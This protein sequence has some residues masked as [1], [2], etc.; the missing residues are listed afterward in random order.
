M[1][2][3]ETYVIQ[4]QQSGRPDFECNVYV[5]DIQVKI[6]GNRKFGF[7]PGIHKHQFKHHYYD[8]YVRLMHMFGYN[9]QFC[10][11]CAEAMIWLHMQL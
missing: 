8:K 10:I 2:I 6:I 3:T 4:S 11:K 7:P 9:L 1:F 5:A